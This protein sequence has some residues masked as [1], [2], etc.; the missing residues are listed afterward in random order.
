MSKLKSSSALAGA[1][2][3]ALVLTGCAAEEDAPME[4]ESSM[5]EEAPT[6][7]ET[8]ENEEQAEQDQTPGNV[9]EVA[10]AAG[11]FE[12]LTQAL[13]SAD[14]VS[15]LESDGPYTVFAPTDDAFAALPEG[16][17]DALLLPENSEVLTSILTYHVV[18]GE[19]MAEDVTTGDVSTVEGSSISIDTSSG[20]V[21]NESANV[22]T[23]DVDASN[24]VIHIIDAVIL[25][26]DVDVDA[27][28]E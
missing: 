22:V 9:I 20:V 17:L 28:L 24:G 26:P 14:L 21:L 19:V 27:L 12:T 2:I 11:S 7:E 4:E 23:T 25:P 6:E 16:L 15:T 8:T 13:E 18:P 10:I 5:S 3:V 1:A